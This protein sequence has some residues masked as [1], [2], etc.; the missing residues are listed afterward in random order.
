MRARLAAKLNFKIDE[1]GGSLL[2]MHHPGLRTMR[3]V[4]VTRDS[5][6]ESLEI[7]PLDKLPVFVNVGKGHHLHFSFPNSLVDAEAGRRIC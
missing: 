7:A 2:M 6:R 5:K 4:T 3:K 1:K